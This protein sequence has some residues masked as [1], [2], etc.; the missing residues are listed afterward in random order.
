[1]RDILIDEPFAVN[2]EVYYEEGEFE[3]KYIYPTFISTS[4]KIYSIN[5]Q[6]FISHDKKY[7]RWLF[8]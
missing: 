6:T 1:M 4:I 2:Y 7:I 3:N 8:N 5:T